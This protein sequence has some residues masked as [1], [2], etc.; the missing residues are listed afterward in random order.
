LAEHEGITVVN[1]YG[2]L[3]LKKNEAGQYDPSLPD[4]EGE[5]SYW[6]HVDYVIKKAEQLGLYI[7]LLPTWGDKFNIMWGKGPEVFDRE[8]AEAYG[9]WLGNRYKD[10]DN[11]IWILGGDRPLYTRRHFDIEEALAAGLRSADGGRH[12]ISYHPSGNSSSSQYLHDETWLDF[13]MIQSGHGLRNNPNY[14]MIQK[15]YEKKPVKPVLDGEPCYEDHPISFKEDNDFFD[16]VDVRKAAYW[17]VFAGG[18]GVT[19]G[20]QCIWSMNTEP[21]LYFAMHWKDAL[22]RP[23]ANQM[24]YLRQLMESRPFF[25]RIPD[26]SLLV[27]NY[28]GFNHQQATRGENYAFIYAPHG[29]F[30]HVKL[31]VLKGESV[32]VKWF[33]PRTGEIIPVGTVKNTGEQKFIPPAHGREHDYVLIMDSEG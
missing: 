9:Q 19:Y 3:P 26:Q 10:Q 1:A 13:N 6:D 18:F 21:G 27:V 29:I 15:D 17:S 2:R 32:S 24:R 20:H 14:R 8:N 4:T 28:E 23:A 31:G 33:V 5:Y 25:E 11:I 7:A 16:A 12:L 30:V 22:G